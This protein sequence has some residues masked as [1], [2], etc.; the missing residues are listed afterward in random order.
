MY[1]ILMQKRR[2]LPAAMNPSIDV[3]KL[4]QSNTALIQLATDV[5]SRFDNLTAAIYLQSLGS[6]EFATQLLI[7]CGDVPSLQRVRQVALQRATIYQG[8]TRQ[9]EHILAIP[10]ISAPAALATVTSTPTTRKCKCRFNRSDC[11]R[12]NPHLRPKSKSARKAPTNKAL[13]VEEVHDTAA[14]TN[15]ASLIAALTAAATHENENGKSPQA[16]RS[17]LF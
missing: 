8:A 4:D 16:P 6:A 1:D 5:N 10:S 13:V 2:E 14:E 3:S 7:D 15:L 17:S 11:W 9:A 12:C